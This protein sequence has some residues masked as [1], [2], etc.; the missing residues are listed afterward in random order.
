MP[1]MKT[2]KSARGRI[3]MSAT[4]KVL[5]TQAGKSHLNGYKPRK[6]KR[7]LRGTT[8]VDKTFVKT[9][10]RMLQGN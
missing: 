6:R 7:N 4:G 1:T 10:V 8:L 9:A 5:R 3:K 2:K